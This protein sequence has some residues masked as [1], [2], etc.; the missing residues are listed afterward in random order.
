MLFDGGILHGAGA[1]ERQVVMRLNGR[2]LPVEICAGSARLNPEVHSKSDN[3]SHFSLGKL[4]CCLGRQHRAP[5]ASSN[6]LS[7]GVIAA[8]R[9]DTD[10]SLEHAA[11]SWHHACLDSFIA[12]CFFESHGAPRK[13]DWRI[14][15]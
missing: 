15:A 9:R 13:V 5:A 7:D 8:L 2:R 10:V 3:P 11:G 6:G 14:V 12:F 4:Q 1:I